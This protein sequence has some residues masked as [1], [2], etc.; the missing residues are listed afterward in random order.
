MEAPVFN[1]PKLKAPCGLS[2]SVRHEFRSVEKLLRQ[3]SVAQ[4]FSLWGWRGSL[5]ATVKTT[6]KMPV[7]P[8]AKMAMLQSH[9]F[10]RSQIGSN[11]G[12]AIPPSYRSLL[13]LPGPGAAARWIGLNQKAHATPGGQLAQIFRSQNSRERN[14]P[15]HHRCE[16]R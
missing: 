14:A 10:Q 15:G 3:E 16:D 9:T 4:A 2:T 7:V 1:A 12:A 8:T 13:M 11:Q 6:G 5:P